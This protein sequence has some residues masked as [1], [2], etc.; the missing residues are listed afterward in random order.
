[1]TVKEGVVI[2][3]HVKYFIYTHPHCKSFADHMILS[4]TY[5]LLQIFLFVFRVH[6]A[7]LDPA[8]S[9]IVADD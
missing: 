2:N 8:G 5:P 7:H 3:Y 9:E 1:M 4:L 6:I